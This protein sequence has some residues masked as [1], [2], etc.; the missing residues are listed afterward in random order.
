MDGAGAEVV[1]N[2]E[3]EQAHRAGVG[4]ALQIAANPIVLIADAVGEQG[5]LELSSRRADSVA[6]AE[7]MT[8]SAGCSCRRLLASK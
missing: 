7:T 8:R 4:V 1:V 3:V 2:V 6:E 5:L